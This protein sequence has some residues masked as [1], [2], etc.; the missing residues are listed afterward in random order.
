MKYMVYDYIGTGTLYL[1]PECDKQ[2]LAVIRE[3]QADYPGRLELVGVFESSMPVAFQWW[4]VC[5]K[6]VEKMSK[7]RQRNADYL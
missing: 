2:E 7:I 6:P 1:V 5:K 4:N 3:M